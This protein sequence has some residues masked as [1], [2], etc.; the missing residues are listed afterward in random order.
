MYS[1]GGGSDCFRLQESVSGRSGGGGRVGEWVDQ[2]TVVITVS[3]KTYI[4]DQGGERS[5]SGKID[6]GCKSQLIRSLLRMS[7]WR[8][9][10]SVG[11]RRSC[12]SC[13]CGGS[14]T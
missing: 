3:W 14:L 1:A 8:R 7:R 6:P 12:P 5:L 13:G 2:E 9:S 4:G 10:G 11:M